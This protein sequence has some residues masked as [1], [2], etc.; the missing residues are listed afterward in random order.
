MLVSVFETAGHCFTLG[1][2][3]ITINASRNAVGIKLNLP[4]LKGVARSAMMGSLV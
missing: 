3:A 2:E 4:Q 1:C